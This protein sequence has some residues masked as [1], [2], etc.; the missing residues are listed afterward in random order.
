MKLSKIRLSSK[1]QL[2]L[3]NDLSTMLTAGIPLLETVEA[4]EPDAKGNLKKILIELHRSLINGETLSRSMS[5]F[6][7]AF[8][9]VVINLMRAAEAGGTLEQTLQDIVHTIKK[10]VAFSKSIKTA[11][12]YPAF[13]MVIFSGILIMLLTF[14]IPR[15]SV[16]FSSM[17]VKIP[18]VTRQLM[19]ASTYFMEHWLLIFG[20]IIAGTILLSVIASKNK[21]FIVRLI[22]S[23]PGLRRLGLNIDLARLTRSLALLLK[24]GVPLDETL[25]LTKRTVNK[26]QIIAVIEQMQRSMNA[27]KPLATG[28]RNTK[29]VIPIMMARSMETAEISGTLEQTLQSL[30]EHFDMQVSDALKAIGTLIEPLLIVIV[31]GMVGMLMLFVIAPVYNMVSQFKVKGM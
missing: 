17:H 9:P 8:E 20:A 6:P 27:G 24:A 21:R 23:L 31:G 30:A 26:K 7:L 16:V 18:W 1:E 22:L 25:I 5:Q 12:V 14:V 11:M 13:V 15:I 19:T 3:F 29:G 4:L 28:L 2:S 10:E